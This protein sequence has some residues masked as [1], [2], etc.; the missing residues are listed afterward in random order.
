MSRTRHTAR[1]VL[2]DSIITGLINIPKPV[3]S[4]DWQRLRDTTA[5]G[6]FGRHRIGLAD[7]LDRHPTRG[8]LTI[9]TRVGHTPDDYSTGVTFTS[10][11]G[12]T[13]PLIRCNGPSHRHRNQIEGDR[14]IRR[15]HVHRLTGR[16]QQ[17]RFKDDG[18][19]QP[20]NEFA[21]LTE[22]LAHLAALVNVT[23]VGTLFL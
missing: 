4:G 18:Y 15:S 14:I 11:D 23:P 6:F 9:Y 20:S 21:N 19:A 5:D 12:D 8:T 13:Y 10:L 7:V 22:A 3:S 16:Y 17:S 1:P 2:D